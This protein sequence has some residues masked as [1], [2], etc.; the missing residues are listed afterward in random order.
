[1]SQ[2]SDDQHNLVNIE[3]FPE[4]VFTLIGKGAY[5]KVYKG[6]NQITGEQYALKVTDYSEDKT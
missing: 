1:M 3:D 6:V 4:V 5:G 2:N